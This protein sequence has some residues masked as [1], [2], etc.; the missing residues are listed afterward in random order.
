MVSAFNKS[1][2]QTESEVLLNLFSY[3]QNVSPNF[4][5]YK[6]MKTI[7]TILAGLFLSLTSN[8]QAL[9]CKKFKTG[10]FYTKQVPDNGYTVRNKK[11][12]TSFYKKNNMEITWKVK[13]TSDCTYELTFDSAKNG[14][15][16][17]KKGDKIIAT[18]TSIDGDCYSFKATFYN[19][20]YATGRE[21]PPADM[22]LKKE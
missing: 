3:M 21:F 11:T 10:T 13:W 17:F 9:D 6:T 22:C 1:Q 14:D 5:P 12:Q 18:I 20:E 15:G 19:S 16:F 8:S 7:L 2:L 4:K